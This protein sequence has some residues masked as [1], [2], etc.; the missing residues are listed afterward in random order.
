VSYKCVIIGVPQRGQAQQAGTVAEVRKQLSLS[1]GLRSFA[2]YAADA[3]QRFSAG[4]IGTIHLFS[5]QRQ[6]GFEEPMAWVPNCELRRMHS[7]CQ[8]T[9]ARSDVVATESPLTPLVKASACGQRQG[10]RW[11][12]GAASQHLVHFGIETP[13]HER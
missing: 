7:Y 6:Y 9:R 2:A 12:H 11:N 1:N 8:A 4:P 3:N 10:M 5:S 13:C